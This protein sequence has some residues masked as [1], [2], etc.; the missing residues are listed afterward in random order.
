MDACLQVIGE[1]GV[2][3]TSHRKVGAV[4]DV[5]L[6]S[7]THHF[8]KKDDLLILTSPRFTVAYTSH[9]RLSAGANVAAVQPVVKL[10]M[11]KVLGT[12]R[13]LVP[14]PKLYTLAARHPEYRSITGSWTSRGRTALK[15]HF[16]QDIAH[17]LNA[18]IE[19]A[20]AFTGHSI[21]SQ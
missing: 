15:Q 8:E 6:G 20:S 1:V 3:G 9:K 14:T 16:D 2:T 19:K 10:N 5:L 4:A 12:G 11:T 21:T 7:M 17:I 18:L 13:K